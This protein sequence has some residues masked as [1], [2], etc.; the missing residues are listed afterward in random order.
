MNNFIEKHRAFIIGLVMMLCVSTLDLITTVWGLSMGGSE[1]NPMLVFLLQ[2][3]SIGFILG[4][5]WSLVV[6]GGGMCVISTFI[7]IVYKS[8]S[9]KELS[10][11]YK[12]FIY[13]IFTSLYIL[14]DIYIIISNI[15]TIFALR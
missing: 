13:A 14:A 5:V 15:A 6:L 12:I 3:G 9:R 10:T 4:L 7:E 11:D 1:M 2:F 8:M